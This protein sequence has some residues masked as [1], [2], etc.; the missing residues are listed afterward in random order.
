[1]TKARR[2][3]CVTLAA[4]AC[5]LL[6]ARTRADSPADGRG[7]GGAD[8]CVAAYES[9]QEQ[10]L[11]GSL[12][13]AREQAAICAAASC[14][15][16]IRD[17]CVAWRGEIDAEVPSVT[18]EVT[19]N[20][21]RVTTVRVTEG[22]R[23]L[24]EGLAGAGVELDPGEHSLRFE[25]DGAEPLTLTVRATRGEKL[26]RVA[27]E[28]V[29]LASPSPPKRE[30]PPKEPERSANVLPWVLVGTGVA[31]MTAFTLLGA[32]GLSEEAKLERS[33]A[34]SCSEEALQSVQTKYLLADVSL[35]VGIGGLV[36]GGYL[37]LTGDEHPAKSARAFPVEVMVGPRGGVASVSGK[38]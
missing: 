14:P 33:C 10:R 18:F 21:A 8:A 6:S 35:V 11:E 19:K 9:A 2:L 29:P 25:A 34:P 20:G 3:G 22:E 30:T 31:G 7:Q 27:V 15:A 37:L 17:D 12:V 24:A 26:R 36:A 32:S 16:F 28:L 23:V 38:F 1:M 13:G 4:A 5:S